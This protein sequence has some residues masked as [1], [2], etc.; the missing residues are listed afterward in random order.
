M[1]RTTLMLPVDLKSKGL[2]AA[3]KKRISFGQ[4]VRE[5]LERHVKDPDGP[6]ASDPLFEDNAVYTGKSAR[7][8]AVNHDRY[9]YPSK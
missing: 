6:S 4:L 9:L 1:K 8:T 3:R 5:A 2:R 7:D